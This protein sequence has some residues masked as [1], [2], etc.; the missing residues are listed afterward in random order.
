MPSADDVLF[1]YVSQGNPKSN[2]DFRR[3]L[4]LYPECREELIDF[5][6]TWRA[7]AIL[8]TILP[9]TPIEAP[10]EREAMRRARMQARAMW[11]RSSGDRGAR[12]N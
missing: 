11:R 3:F 12:S 4:R 8:D 2:D 5:T 1:E 9:P 10:I 6:A 7:L